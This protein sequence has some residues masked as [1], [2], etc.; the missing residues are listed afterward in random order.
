MSLLNRQDL[1]AALTRVGELAQAQSQ[2][3]E[4]LLLG[5]SLM[6]LAYGT[7]QATRDVDVVILAPPQAESVRTI[8]RMIGTERGWPD[9]WLNDAAKG[10]LIGATLGPVVFSAPGIVVYRPAIEQLLA[11]KLSAWRDDVDV[12]DARRLLQDLLGTHDEIWASIIPHLQPGRELKAKFA[13]DDL[14]EALHGSH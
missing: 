8:A 13:Y 6:V 3:V 10:F 9:D 11:M 5:G 7:R 2:S 14:W 1:V 4:L 12:A